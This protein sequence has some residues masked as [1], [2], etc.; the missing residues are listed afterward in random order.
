MPIEINHFP[1]QELRWPLQLRSGDQVKH[2]FPVDYN[3]ASC[4]E[5]MLRSQHEVVLPGG[6]VSSDLCEMTKTIMIG[7]SRK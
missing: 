3:I 1:F 4:S 6:E 7:A 5:W 2:P